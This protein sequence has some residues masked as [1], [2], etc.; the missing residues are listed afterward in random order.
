MKVLQV[1]SSTNVNSGIANVVMNYYR[2]INRERVQFDFL[3]FW[4]APNNFNKEIESYGGKVYY[5]TKPGLTTYFKAK[6][7][8]TD[9]F[10]EHK[11]EYDIVHCHE[12]LVAK[13]VFKVVR[14]FDKDVVC[15]SHSHSSK[16]SESKIRTLRN[17]II[18]S[19][20]AKKSD[21]CF[22]CSKIAA[23]CAYGK[24]ILNSPKYR[25]VLNAI[26]LERFVFSEEKRAEIRDELGIKGKI[27]LGNVGR[28]DANKNQI[29]AIKI[30][31]EVIKT[32]PDAVLLLI[33]SGEMKERLYNYVSK[34]GL[35]NNVIF[36]GIRKDI[37]DILSAMDCFIFPSKF[38]GFGIALIE[39]QAN[40]LKCL[41]YD[42]LPEEVYENDNV[43]ALPEDS[44]PEE[45]AKI[46]KENCTYEYTREC[47]FESM[48]AKGLDISEASRLLE[49]TYY[50]ML[51]YREK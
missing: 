29:F 46:I 39:A 28:L 31:Q 21:Y 26:S 48:K 6:K 41:C 47:G 51:E 13:N 33:G 1:I 45:W 23:I 18:I 16:L 30:L 17:R 24:D 19:G 36:A 15:I 43:F 38:E 3:V 50:K 37:P 14:R 2:H 49:E 25:T 20:L 42:H 4:E 35:E 7:D 12:I 11:G 34:N 40:G 8:L 32:V 22:A 9:F 27:V 10:A 44:S 5:F